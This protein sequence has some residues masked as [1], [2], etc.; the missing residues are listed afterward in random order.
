SG[1]LL[2]L[3]AMSFLL[4]KLPRMS[5][6]VMTVGVAVV[7]GSVILTRFVEENE[8]T[9]TRLEQTFDSSTS[10]SKRTSGRSDLVAVG[11]QMF[12][13]R[14]LGN[15]TGSFARNY[16][17][18]SLDQGVEFHAGREMAA[19]SAWVKVLAEN[20]LPGILLLIAF[21]CSFVWVGWSRR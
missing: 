9:A 1:I 13:D 20:G 17:R 8:Y 10:I 19:H 6:R 11:W 21:C 18:A 16:A 5:H 2:C 7:L 3:I 15:G 12:L 4:L 14:P